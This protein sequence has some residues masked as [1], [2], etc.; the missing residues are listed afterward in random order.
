MEEMT[1]TFKKVLT[2]VA[3]SAL[4]IQ[5][6]ANAASI[7]TIGK[8]AQVHKTT[9]NAD[10]PGNE[11]SQILN[12]NFIKDTNYDK[13]VLVLKTAG[14]INSGYQAPDPSQYSASSLRWGG[15]YNVKVEVASKDAT[16]IIDYAPKN[17]NEAHEV[18]STV[19]YNIG[20]D[21]K[22]SNSLSGA[23]NGGYSFSETINYKQDSYKTS[24]LRQTNPK[25]VGWEVEAN[26]IYVNG[27][28]PYT[29][30]QH[31]NF[32]Y[33]NE[34]FL[35]SRSANVYAGQNFVHPSAMPV[36]ARGNFN[37]EFISV[38]THNPK[39]NGKETL[40]KVTYERKVDKY[41]DFW[42]GLHWWGQNLKNF[43]SKTLVATYKVDWDK[44]NAKLLKTE[45]R[46]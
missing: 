2:S 5:G 1:M 44:H 35:A 7:E 40:L 37:P 26:K 13:E 6:A 25:Q 18:T 32:T 24:L 38:L 12:F 39:D 43:E 31:Y 16:N 4:F 21:I 11:I 17:Q 10:E 22:V 8:G 20:G 23:G 33:G 28:G 42:N 27:Y 15:Q 19:G 30:A 9:A 3:L 29:R 36:L 14:T 45:V 34:L 41:Q 46:G